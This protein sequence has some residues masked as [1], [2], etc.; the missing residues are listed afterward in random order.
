MSVPITAAPAVQKPIDAEEYLCALFPEHAKGNVGIVKIPKHGF[1]TLP[2]EP[3]EDL[4]DTTYVCISTLDGEVW[5][6]KNG[7]PCPPLIKRLESSCV[8]TW[9]VFC[10]DVG[11]APPDPDGKLVSKVDPKRFAGLLPPTGKLETSLDNYQYVYAFKD[12]VDPA[13]ATALV[14]G[15]VAAGLSDAG[16]Q[17]ANRVMR[18]PGA[19]NRKRGNFV[20]RLVEWHPDRLYSYEEVCAGLGVTPIEKSAPEPDGTRVLPDGMHDPAFEWLARNGSVLSSGP[21]ARGGWDIT[22]PWEHEHGP[23]DKQGSTN[24]FPGHPGGFSCLHGHCAERTGHTLCQ[25]IREQ[26]PG[27]D[28]S[29]IPREELQ[30]IGATLREVLQPMDMPDGAFIAGEAKTVLKAFQADLVHIGSEDKFWSYEAGDGA[31]GETGRLI[32]GSA[33]DTRWTA[34]LLE[35]GLLTTVTAA[36]NPSKAL[37]TPINVFRRNKQSQLLGGLIHRLGA[38]RVIGN[39]LN[40]APGLPA[41]LMAEGKVEP[42]LELVSFVCKDIAAD[43]EAMLDWLALLVTEWDEKPGWHPLLRGP[44]GVGKNLFML[45]V[46][47]YLKPYHQQDVKAV[48]LDQRFNAFLTKRLISVDELKQNTRGAATGHDIYGYLKAYTAQGT[49]TTSIE[50]KGKEVI[51]ALNLSGWLLTSNEMVPLPIEADDRRFMTIETPEQKK[52]KPWYGAIARWLIK[53]NGSANVVSWLHRRWDAMSAERRERVIGGDAPMTAAKLALIEL[54]ATGVAGALRM[55]LSGKHDVYWPDLMQYRDI[56]ERLKFTDKDL[57]TENMRRNFSRG[58][59]LQALREIGARQLFNGTPVR[60]AK[61]VQARLW[62]MRRER[63]EQYEKMGQTD[64]LM[65]SYRAKLKLREEE[66]QQAPQK[67]SE[68][69]A[70]APFAPKQ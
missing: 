47:E 56:E 60:D 55:A 6:D 43:H 25:W 5:V 27:A 58:M 54:S 59:L 45:P 51:E 17:C 10:D 61:G 41:R 39:C 3:D 36:G 7:V 30:A 66:A 24:W 64:L 40:I 62:C 28:L 44:Q 2:W 19:V 31:A 9:C 57:L 42:W 16:A 8:E 4:T 52:P 69:G 26:D 46:V 29:P 37:L 38:P 53:E 48:N 70:I 68:G 13:K 33:V 49:T 14:R 67:E 65:Q 35:A 18:V 23:G 32:T 11:T 50:Y 12:P 34:R 1:C 63:I 21:N 15:M 20:A 22:C